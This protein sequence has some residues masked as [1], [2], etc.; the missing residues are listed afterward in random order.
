MKSARTILFEECIG[1]A[2]YVVSCLGRF[3]VVSVLRYSFPGFE[4]NYMN[5]KVCGETKGPTEGVEIAGDSFGTVEVEWFVSDQRGHCLQKTG[6][7]EYVIS[8]QVRDHY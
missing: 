8:V 4:L 5:G 3:D 6:E 2:S 7:S 1:E